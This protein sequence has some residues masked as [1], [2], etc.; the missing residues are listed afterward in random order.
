MVNNEP[1]IRTQNSSYETLSRIW[2]VT[3]IKVSS[4]RIISLRGYET[5]VNH[6]IPQTNKA[7]NV[8]VNVT[9]RHFRVTIVA[10]EKQ[11]VGLLHIL[12][13]CL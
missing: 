1:H 9:L 6:V 10:I 13:V 12:S 3:P 5:R 4:F 8:H 7:S 11:S 2:H